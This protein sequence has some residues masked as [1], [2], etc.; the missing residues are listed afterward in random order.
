MTIKEMLKEI[1]PDIFEDELIAIGNGLWVDFYIPDV[2][3][4]HNS[5][6]DEEYLFFQGFC[7][8]F[9]KF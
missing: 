3:G 6:F 1:K 9:L 8:D 7:D 5:N 2:Y 4:D